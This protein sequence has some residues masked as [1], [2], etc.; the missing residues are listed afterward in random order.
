MV[1][2]SL[3]NCGC[4]VACAGCICLTHRPKRRPNFEYVAMRAAAVVFTMVAVYR[5]ILPRIDVPRICWFDTPANWI[6]F[7]RAAATVAELAWAMQMGLQLRRLALCLPRARCSS[8]L[9]VVGLIVIALAAIAECFSWTN[10]V[11]EN[12]A[13]AVVEQFLWGVLF[14]LTGVGVAALL[15][16]WKN[17]SSPTPVAWFSYAFFA[18]LV[19]GMGVE[20]EV[21]AFALYLPRYF[22][23]IDGHKQ[24]TT[25]D[26]LSGGVKGFDRL[27]ACA[28]ASHDWA[29]WKM[30]AAWMTAYFSVGVW[31]SLW[32][33]V[34]PL[35]PLRG[36]AAAADALL[37]P[38]HASTQT[39]KQTWNR[40]ATPVQE[41]V[42]E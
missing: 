3:F 17:S 38:Q 41:I 28:T 2:I 19:A 37:L 29:T 7:G 27:A 15:P 23:Q 9:R 36:E 26:H 18:L 20:Q 6:V 35:P 24:N 5:S 30:D 14:L 8:S 10:L 13:F 39:W 21:E 33:A 22:A 1:A 11:T 31:T 34:V 12:N 16:A 40:P 42:V 4:L 25:H 32:L